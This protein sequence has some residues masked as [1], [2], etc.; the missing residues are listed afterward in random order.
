MIVAIAALRH[1]I[2]VVYWLCCSSDDTKTSTHQ[3]FELALARVG[4]Y[5]NERRPS[6]EKPAGP[7]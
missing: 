2:L 6:S 3:E 4:S 7:A 1:I 5:G